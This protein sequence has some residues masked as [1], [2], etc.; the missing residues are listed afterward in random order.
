MYLPVHSLGVMRA[1]A[2]GNDNARA[3]AQADKQ[4]HQ[5]IDKGARGPHRRQRVCAHKVA[6]DQRIRRVVQL[7]EQRA[8]PDRQKEEQQLL[9]DA[10]GQN[11]RLF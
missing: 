4:P 8:E 3:A 6:D 2:L 5:Q 11:I 1:P 7:L 9:G 10:A